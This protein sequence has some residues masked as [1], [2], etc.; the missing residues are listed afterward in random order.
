MGQVG[1]D[2]RL[3]SGSGREVPCSEGEECAFIPKAQE[4]MEGLEPKA[5]GSHLESS[6]WQLQKEQLRGDDPTR[7]AEGR[8]WECRCGCARESV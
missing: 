6:L 8:V 1:E 2:S 5:A 3:G 7:W 4:L